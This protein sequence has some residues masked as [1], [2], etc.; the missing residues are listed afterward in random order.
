MGGEGG[1]GGVL[2]GTWGLADGTEGWESKTSVS[3]P[4]SAGNFP[5]DLEQIL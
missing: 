3:W 4:S 1:S 2:R 5:Y